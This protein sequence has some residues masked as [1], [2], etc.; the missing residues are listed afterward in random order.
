MVTYLIIRNTMS[1]YLNV[2]QTN[3]PTHDSTTKTFRQEMFPAH[4]TIRDVRH[5]IN[6][7]Y[8]QFF[9]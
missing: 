8:I 5:S 9:I 4:D 6:V 3:I 1:M 7:K 2:K